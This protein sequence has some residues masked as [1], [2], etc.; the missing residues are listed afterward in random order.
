MA[1]RPDASPAQEAAVRKRL[2]EIQELLKQGSSFAEL[3]QTRSEGPAAPMGGDIDFKSKESLDPAY[4]QA[5]LALG[6]PGKVTGVV[7]TPFGLHLI[8]LTAI[9]SWEDA[10]HGQVK[11]QLFEEKR[12]AMFEKYLGKLRQEAKVSVNTSLLKD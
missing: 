9:R 7:K 2:V 10:D 4:Y 3:A 8:K 5:A 6:K 1:L 11:R 12:A